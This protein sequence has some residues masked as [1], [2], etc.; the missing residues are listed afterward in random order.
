MKVAVNHNVFTRYLNIKDN[1]RCGLS[2]CLEL[3][4]GGLCWS[5]LNPKNF[6]VRNIGNDRLLYEGSFKV[7]RHYYN[8]GIDKKNPFRRIN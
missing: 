3:L 6:F 8:I 2:C 5:R 7:A 4:I 1:R